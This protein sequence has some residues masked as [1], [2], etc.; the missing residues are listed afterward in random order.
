MRK[1][2]SLGVAACIFT[3]AFSFFM[4]GCKK[5][6][7]NPITNNMTASVN[8]SSFA[9]TTASASNSNNRL[10]LVGVT[11]GTPVKEIQIWVDNPAVGSYSLTSSNV[12][13]GNTA[14]YAEGPSSA[15]LTDY[16]TDSTHTG[17][18][19][20]SKLD[21]SAR[22]VSGSFSFNAV[23]FYPTASTNTVSVSSGSFTDLKW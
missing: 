14:I 18:L 19:T 21:N 20:I 5:T 10:L 13:A 22:T 3:T 16:W 6:T 2:Y 1:I 15:M 11:T 17:T 7:S 23:Q 12:N 9:T 4:S 8:G